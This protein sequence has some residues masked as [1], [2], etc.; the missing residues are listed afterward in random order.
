MS[1][2]NEIKIMLGN[3]H[4]SL[5]EVRDR[6]RRTETRLTRFIEQSGFD[7]KVTRARYDPLSSTVYLPSPDCSLRETID[8]VP[9]NLRV[10]TLTINVMVNDTLI[11]VMTLP[12]L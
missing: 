3:M 1:V 5:T 10:S 9:A 8:A 12:A 6:A 7:A 4:T 11:A 2:D